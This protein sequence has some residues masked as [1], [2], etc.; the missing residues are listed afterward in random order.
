ML[1]NKHIHEIILQL[2]EV[3]HGQAANNAFLDNGTRDFGYAVFAKVAEGMDVVD[4]IAKTETS[5]NGPHQ[6]VP[7]EPIV[8]NSAKRVEE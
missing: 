2:I 3:S 5:N 7:V 6:N 1:N 4:E 8:V